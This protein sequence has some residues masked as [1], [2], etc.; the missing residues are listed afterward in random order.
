MPESNF[1][2]DLFAETG[3]TRG[4][5]GSAGSCESPPSVREVAGSVAETPPAQTHERVN[6]GTTE[7]DAETETACSTGPDTSRSQA[8]ATV[9]TN[10]VPTDR[11][12]KERAAGGSGASSVLAELAASQEFRT[13]LERIAQCL[14]QEIDNALEIGR[15]AARW[16]DDRKYHRVLNPARF[17]EQ[18]KRHTG[19]ERS[20]KDIENYVKAY[21]VHECI[22]QSGKRLPHL[23]VSHLRQIARCQDDAERLELAQ[24]VNDQKAPVKRIRH[25]AAQLRAERARAE[26]TFEVSPTAAKVQVMDG[27]DLVKQQADGSISCLMVDWQW[28]PVTW[29]GNPD[30]P[31]V[32]CSTDPVGDLCDCLQVAADKLTETGVICLFHSVWLPDRRLQDAWEGAGLR[33]AGPVIW[34]TPCGVFHDPSLLVNPA[35]GPVY[36]LCKKHA[37]PT[38][39]SRVSSVTPKWAAPTTVHSGKQG[40]VLHPHQKPIE[41]MELLISIAT[42]DGLVVDPY[43]GSGSCGV[44]A[45]RRGCRYVGAEIV[46]DYARIANERIVMA[47]GEVEEVT[48]AISFFL[49]DADSDQQAA[50]AGV[51]AKAGLECL[52][53]HQVKEKEG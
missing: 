43:A 18:L 51:L 46:P 26:R 15:I 19:R 53:K 23:G 48:E 16:I 41:L 24:R 7:K 36:L 35:H 34:P 4:P 44:A 10:D 6:V 8:V 25:I 45:V 37:T 22:S 12:P 52:S 40:D 5:E 2:I 1:L 29:G 17:A 39:A 9:A 42:A 30:F 11:A 21:Q 50:I 33:Y 31:V 3:E 13:D 28:C 14:D 27:L 47:C 38:P 32:H 49:K 20:R